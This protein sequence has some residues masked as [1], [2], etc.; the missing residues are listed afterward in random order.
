[1]RGL[2][3]VVDDGDTDAAS[4][5]CEPGLL[6]ADIGTGHATALAGVLELPLFGIVRVVGARA[7]IDL[8]QEHRFGEQKAGVALQ[9]LRGFDAVALGTGQHL[10]QVLAEAQ[11]AHNLEA[12]L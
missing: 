3:T 10:V 4:A 9:R 7:L 11:R 2:E 8:L 12:L 6:G 5:C 1:V